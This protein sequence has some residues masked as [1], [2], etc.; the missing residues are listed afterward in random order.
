MKIINLMDMLHALNI[1]NLNSDILGNKKFNDC[2][3]DFWS[4][5]E[6]GLHKF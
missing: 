4:I 2:W 3:L 1:D 6:S 5:E